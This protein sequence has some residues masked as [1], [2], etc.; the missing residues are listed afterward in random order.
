MIHSEAQLSLKLLVIVLLKLANTKL[1]RCSNY[2]TMAIN[3]DD[4]R[5]RQEHYCIYYSKH[6]TLQSLFLKI[7][8]KQVFST[9]HIKLDEHI[10]KPIV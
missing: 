3:S 5:S 2:W 6:S 8:Y 4:V 1:Q 9:I 10:Y 7:A